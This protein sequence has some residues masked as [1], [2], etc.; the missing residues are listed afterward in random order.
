MRLSLGIFAH[1][2]GQNIGATLESLFS[3]TLFLAPTAKR[4]GVDALEVLCLANGCRDRTVDVANSY[5]RKLP[6]FVSYRVMD[7]PQPGKSRTCNAFVHELSDPGADFLV[8]MDA[9]IIF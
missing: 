2:E 7:L 1:N 9:D 8:A 6:P 5:G 4:N 3:Q